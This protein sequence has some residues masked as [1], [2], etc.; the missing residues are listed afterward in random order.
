VENLPTARVHL[1]ATSRDA[2]GKDNSGSLLDIRFRRRAADLTR[3]SQF[4]TTP[5]SAVLLKDPEEKRVGEVALGSS[6]GWRSGA[7]LGVA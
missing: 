2:S 5:T 6:E 4:S 3:L 1:A 7:T